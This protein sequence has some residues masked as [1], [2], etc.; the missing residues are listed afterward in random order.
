MK[1]EGHAMSKMSRLIT[2]AILFTLSGL[3]PIPASAGAAPNGA[4]GSVFY[5][6]LGTSLSVGIQPNSAGQD[7]RTQEG[8]ANQL[9][10]AL[11]SRIPGLQLVKLGCLGETT[12][13][14]ISG[15]VCQYEGGSQLA[16]AVTFLQDHAGSVALVTIEMGAND[17]EPCGSLSGIDQACVA[18]AFAN[19]GRNLPYIVSVLR[20]A[21]G[22]NTP[23]VG[24]NYYNP[25]V[26]AWFEDPALARSSALG[27]GFFNALLGGVY[28][29]F[30]IPVADVAAAFDSADF[31]LVPGVGVPRNVLLVCQWTWMCA[32]PPVGPNIH[33]NPEGYGVIA[34]AFLAVLP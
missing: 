27:L 1:T 16:D 18:Q 24:M 4:P 26:A 7:R 3:L 32:P 23:I 17:I 10:T 8:Y 22:P 9:Y 19:V 13:T 30:A 31:T 11:S 20:T 34:G 6:S 28:S 29:A 12:V 21:A 5:L 14:M 33:A 25:F 2:L 15:G